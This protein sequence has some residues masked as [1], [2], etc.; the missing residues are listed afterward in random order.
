MSLPTGAAKI[1][2]YQWFVSQRLQRGPMDI[3]RVNTIDIFL[4]TSFQQ[5]IQLQLCHVDFPQNLMCLLGHLHS[6]LF[7]G[8]YYLLL[9]RGFFCQITSR[10]FKNKIC[11]VDF[12]YFDSFDDRK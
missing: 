1:V 8:L 6:L 9:L 11:E 12:I 10:V 3:A 4:Q 7:V 2:K 5:Q